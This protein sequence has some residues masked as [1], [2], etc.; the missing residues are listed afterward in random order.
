MVAMAD[1]QNSKVVVSRT[2]PASASD[3]FDILSDPGKHQSFD[4]SGFVRGAVKPQRISGTGQVFRMDM[5]GDHMG[6]DYQTDNTVVG[7]DQNK[8]IAWKTAPA[9][10]EP[11]GWEWVWELTPNGPDSTDVQLTYDWSQVSDP[12]LL[13]KVKF[14]LVTPEQLDGSLERLSE[15]AGN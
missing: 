6:G 1:T 9:G 11:P 2:I 4:G 10:T 7:F 13:K 15:A 5:T 12:E 8:L 3:I 14:P